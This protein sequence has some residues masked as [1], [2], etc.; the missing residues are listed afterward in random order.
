MTIGGAFLGGGVELVPAGSCKLVLEIRTEDGKNL[1]TTFSVVGGGQTYTA[2]AGADGRAEIIVPSGVT[3]TVTTSATGYDG[4]TTQ[5]VIGD[6]ATVQY[7]RFEATLPRVKKSG[8]TMPGALILAGNPFGTIQRSQISYDQNVT[9]WT[10]IY[11]DEVLDAKDNSLGYSQRARSVGGD[12]SLYDSLAISVRG[13]NKSGEAVIK[14]YKPESAEGYV[15]IPSWSVGT[16]DNST[17]ALTI[18]MANS[19]PSLCHSSG[20]ETW[21]GTKTFNAPPII[22]GRTSPYLIIKST[23]LLENL[24]ESK[25]EYGMITFRGGDDATN[26]ASLVVS[27]ST[28][29]YRSRWF[30]RHVDSTGKE[31][32]VA[33]LVL[34]ANKDGTSWVEATTTPSDAKANEIATANWVNDKFSALPKVYRPCGSVATF[35]QLPTNASIGDVYNVES[36]NQNYAWVEIDGVQKWDSL[37]ATIDLTQYYTKT[38]VDGKL[39]EV[40]TIADGKVSKSGDT[41]SDTLTIVKSE[42]IFLV[43]KL[44]GYA[45][46]NTLNKRQVVSNYVH[47]KN[48][49]NISDRFTA[50]YPDNSRTCGISLWD[51]SRRYGQ[52]YVQSFNDGTF[53]GIA[54][55]WSVGTN[56]NSDKI[57]TMKMANSLPSLVHTTGNETINGLK[58]FMSEVQVPRNGVNFRL[59]NAEITRGTF[60]S[61]GK[62]NRI[63]WADVSDAEL[64]GIQMDYT[65][66]GVTKIRTYVTNGTHAS[67]DFGVVL[68]NS[69][70]TYGTAPTTPSNATSNEIATANWVLGKLGSGALKK[71]DLETTITDGNLY[72]NNLQVGDI[73]VLNLKTSSHGAY[74]GAFTYTGTESQ[75]TFG[76]KVS[77]LKPSSG[78]PY[79]ESSYIWISNNGGTSVRLS[80]LYD[81]YTLGATTYTSG[82]GTIHTPSGF[83]LR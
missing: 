5:T 83:I 43:E 42:G 67:W 21:S 40:R 20:N 58:V 12:G 9:A 78:T 82:S 15:E 79:I 23:S 19:L 24:T 47:D 61:T 34:R 25:L 28:E 32:S 2:T 30:T 74:S 38:D 44:N 27:R 66:S 26:L 75:Q 29:E 80:C 62:W 52:L 71:I 18:R 46:G 65:T 3:Y 60:P 7:V 57:L 72:I 69:G 70:V 14:L 33:E 77:F 17:K 8:D 36:D 81:K 22:G 59:K 39:S 64:G 13:R 6:S 73:V 4:L 54:S 10:R 1:A 55:S 11:Q 68:E 49:T 45:N 16:N 76:S 63:Q 51:E 35:D 56:D 37:G 53:C 31:K 50:I 48:N 41:M